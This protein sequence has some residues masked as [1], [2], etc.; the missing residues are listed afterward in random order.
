[1]DRSW[2]PKVT[3]ISETRDLTT[4]TTVALFGKLREH[5]LEMIRLKEMETVEKKTR[6]LALK[7]RTVVQESTYESS[8]D[9]SEF[10]DINLLTRKFHKF[11]KMKNRLKNQQGKRGK[12]KTDSG[13]TKL[14]C[15]GC[16]KQ[17]HMKA[18]CPSIAT[19]DKAPEKKSNKFGKTRRAYIAWE[20]N[21]TSSSCSSEDEI[22]ANTCMMAGR[23]SDVNSTESSA[24]FNSTNYNTLLHAFQET[25]EEANKLAQSNRRL[26]GMNRW[27]ENRVKQLED[28]LL[29]A[30]DDLENL[31]KQLNSANSNKLNSCKPV[32]CENCSKPVDCENCTVL[33]NK[34]N[35]LITT[36]S[37]LSMGTTNLTALLGS[38][39]CVFEKA[40]IGY[41][42]GPNG[43][44][45][46]FNNFFKGFGSQS[47]QS[48]ACFYCMRKGHSV[49]NCTIRKCSVPK[50]LVRWVP[51]STS[52][53]AGPKLNRVP[54]P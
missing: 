37:K 4:L 39:N 43:K 52:N 23:D 29:E 8:G 40:G 7:T 42:A 32:N 18:E 27:L 11:I 22:E 54:N 31:E 1:L 34:V 45:K 38:Q 13:S 44:Q 5:E 12:N 46:L 20:D 30:K 48:I 24:S 28:E 33:Q 15:F 19:K 6:S 53:T 21:A 51:K 25:H 17:G 49:R 26:K 10:E 16:G 2:Q 50:G 36:A 35:Y 47:S 14:V 9:C 3:A 41:Q